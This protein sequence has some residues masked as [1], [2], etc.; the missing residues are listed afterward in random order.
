MEF[1]FTKDFAF[2]LD[3][4]DSL[5]QY[6]NEFIFPTV[7]G[8]RALYFSGNSLG[9]QA[10]K[11]KQILLEELESW[12]RLGAKGH[13]K[14]QRPWISYHEF[15]T[16]S[17]AKVVGAKPEEVVAMNGLTTNLHLLMVSFYHPQG[18]RSKILCE[19]RAFPSDQYV[20]R[21]QIRHHGLDSKE[22]LIEVMPDKE[23]K[24]IDEAKIKEIIKQ[25]GDE[26]ALLMMGGVNY[27]SG[28][29]LSIAEITGAA[30][31]RGITVGWDL[32]HAAGNVPLNL[33][34]WEVDFAAWCGYKYLNSGPGGV[35]GIFIHEKHHRKKDI[36]R[37]EGWWGHNKSSRFSMPD[38]FI[39]IPTAEAWQ[40]SNAPVFSMAPLLASLELFD[41]AG[42]TALRK[43]SNL[44][45]SYL[46]YVITKIGLDT[47]REL[48]I[49]TPPNSS[50]RGCQ[51]SIILPKRGGEIYE[52]ITANGVIADW[53]NPGVIRLAP[54][55]LYNSFMNVYEFGEI[56]K[57]S[58][59]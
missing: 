21:S 23:T 11:V 46:E 56:L 48:K 29:L 43:K 44:L 12:A 35:S 2:K 5:S 58:I 36:A 59:T 31:D 52:K 32:A 20:L 25:R 7:N 16:E 54:V 14:A 8:K 24:I 50:K 4:D 51:L 30:H 28:Q 1:E 40:L 26:I 34:D 39:P 53:R 47:E 55:P 42:M 37:F 27:Y 3:C 33:H 9:L 45:T 13:T 22:H 18:K 10:K 38:E 17:L 49:L 19:G 15:F 57:R 41:K 6:R